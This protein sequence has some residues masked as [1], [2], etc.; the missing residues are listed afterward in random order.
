MMRFYHV[1]IRFELEDG[2]SAADLWDFN[3]LDQM[4]GEIVEVTLDDDQGL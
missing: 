3:K 1:T 4:S 2:Q